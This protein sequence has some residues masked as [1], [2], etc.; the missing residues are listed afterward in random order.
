MY[1]LN[2]SPGFIAALADLVEARYAGELAEA[3]PNG[4]GATT[5]NTAR[6]GSDG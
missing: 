5:K 2:D 6:E 4:A 3:G 1:A